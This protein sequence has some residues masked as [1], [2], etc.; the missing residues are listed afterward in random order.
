MIVRIPS[1]LDLRSSSCK[2]LNIDQNDIEMSR[3]D[4]N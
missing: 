2:T 3:E 4:C 1:P